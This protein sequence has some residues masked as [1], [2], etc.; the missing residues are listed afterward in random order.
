[1]SDRIYIDLEAIMARI[2]EKIRDRGARGIR[3]LGRLFRIADDD[4]SNCIDLRNELPKLLGD[5]GV[6]LNKTEA[7][8]LARLLDRNGDGTISYE[9]FIYYFAPP[10]N[11]FRLG[12][13]NK[14]F[15]S[16]DK[17]GNGVLD[18]EDLKL[19]HAKNAANPT[20]QQQKMS[21]PEVLFRNLTSVFDKNGDGVVSRQE[22]IDYYRELN[23]SIDNDEYFELL[24][25]NAWGF[26]GK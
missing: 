10:L 9:E 25:N 13:I 23:P 17:N 22:F 15:D 19:L 1:M 7:M 12:L 18:V 3:G 21:S 6:L 20:R 16:L 26:A 5:I 14:V 11:E 2:R 4:G 8:E 24:I